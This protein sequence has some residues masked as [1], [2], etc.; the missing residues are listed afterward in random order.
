M[1]IWRWRKILK[2]PET[3]SGENWE[4]VG[5]EVCAHEQ[6]SVSELWRVTP[7]TRGTRFLSSAAACSGPDSHTSGWYRSHQLTTASHHPTNTRGYCPPWRV[8]FAHLKGVWCWLLDSQIWELLCLRTQIL[9]QGQDQGVGGGRE[10][11]YFY[12][13]LKTCKTITSWIF[14]LPFFFRT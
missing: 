5:H 11:T 14:S 9:E 8:L 12:K 3:E 7:G 6:L 4:K 13:V 10:T 2:N 1:T